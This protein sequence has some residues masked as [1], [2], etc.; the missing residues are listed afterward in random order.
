MSIA[1]I[2]NVPSTDHELA[3][4]SFLHMALHRSENLAIL[5]KYNILL[6]ENILDPVD[7]TP[8]GSWFQDHQVMH[9]NIDQVLGVAQFNL[10]DVDWDNESQRIG[11]IQGHA[12]LHQTETNALDVFS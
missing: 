5:R 8:G 10:L 12:Q 11:W 7:T 1:N 6:P 4:W 2:F 9:N 3:E